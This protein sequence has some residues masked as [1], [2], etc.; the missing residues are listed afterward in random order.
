[1]F[2]YHYVMWD[3]FVT[4]QFDQLIKSYQCSSCQRHSFGAMTILIIVSVLSLRGLRFKLLNR[5]HKGF[6]G[7]YGVMTK[8]SIFKIKWSRPRAK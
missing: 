1:M 4:E 7:G 6:H 8:L 3:C 5:A 2:S